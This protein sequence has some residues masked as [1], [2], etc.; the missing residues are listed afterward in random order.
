MHGA[1]LGW[2]LAVVLSFGA[3]VATQDLEMQVWPRG[4]A[5]AADATDDLPCA[6]ALARTDTRPR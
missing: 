1:R 4:R 3:T 5:R 6:H 2:G